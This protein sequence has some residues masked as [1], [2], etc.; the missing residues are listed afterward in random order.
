MDL[1]DPSIL[2][3]GFQGSSGT[4]AFRYNGFADNFFGSGI[5]YR[6]RSGFL[7]GNSYLN[8]EKSGL[9]P[10]RITLIDHLNSGFF[11]KKP[12]SPHDSFIRGLKKVTDPNS[13]NQRR[14][15]C[16]ETADHL[17]PVPLMRL[18]VS[19]ATGLAICLHESL[20]RNDE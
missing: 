6:T 18:L 2:K 20:L 3:S 15:Q 9:L 19:I 4:G 12:L 7:I 16:V 14:V 1:A 13:S 11:K 17:G 5:G 10:E 8:I